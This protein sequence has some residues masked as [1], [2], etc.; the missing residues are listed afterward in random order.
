MNSAVTLY[1]STLLSSP[2]LPYPSSTTHRETLAKIEQGYRMPPPPG[3]TDTLYN[4]MLDT[5]KQDPDERP[6]FGYL[7]YILEDYADK[8]SRRH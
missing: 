4:I 5:W 8:I 7:K 3:C 6:T 1:N 2:S